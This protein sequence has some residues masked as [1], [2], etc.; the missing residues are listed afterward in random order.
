MTNR[1]NR[2]E[3]NKTYRS[4]EASGTP[5]HDQIEN[6]SKRGQILGLFAG[7]SP[8]SSR[9][10]GILLSILNLRVK[11]KRTHCSNAISTSISEEYVHHE[12]S[13][14]NVQHFL[15]ANFTDNRITYNI[16]INL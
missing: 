6:R 1:K 14:V 12:H 9:E 4:K 2:E 15:G 13:I 16:Y 5:D 3:T 10:R 11:C 7:R 8:E